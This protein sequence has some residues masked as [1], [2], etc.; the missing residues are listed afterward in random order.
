MARDD[1]GVRCVVLTSSHEK[2]FCAGGSLTSS[3]PRCRWCTSTSPPSASRALFK[4]IGQLGKPTHLRGQRA[5]ARRLAGHRAGL[6][7]DRGQGHRGLRHARDQ[8]GDLPLHDHGADLPQRP[9]QEDQRDAAAG[10][11]AHRGGGARGGDRE[12]GGARRGVRRRGRRLGPE[13][14]GQVAADDA[15]G[16]GRDVP[17]ARH[18][19]RRGAGL[20]ALAARRSPSPPRTSRRACPPSSRSGSPS[21]PAGEPGRPALPHQRPHAAGGRGGRRARPAGGQAAGARAA[22]DR[23]AR[24]AASAALRRGPGAVARLPAGGG[25]PGRR[26]PRRGR[27][28]GRRSPPSARWR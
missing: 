22:G 26:R 8:R 2:V 24:R 23:H 9:A 13:A 25:R 15:A 14:G 3:P 28:P 19:L 16:Q 10:R 18:V 4:L 21:G 27:R 1:D 20:P 5:R 7:P 11:A 6:R 17:P 12:Q